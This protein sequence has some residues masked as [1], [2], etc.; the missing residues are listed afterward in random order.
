MSD[1]VNLKSFMLTSTTPALVELA[2]DVEL[3]LLDVELP[4]PPPQAAR[5]M[6]RTTSPTA[7]S[8]RRRVSCGNVFTSRGVTPRPRSHS[9]WIANDPGRK[10]QMSPSKRTNVLSKI[11]QDGLADGPPGFSKAKSRA[12]PY[13]PPK[14]DARPQCRTLRTPG[15]PPPTPTARVRRS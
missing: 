12:T 15:P 6:A 2:V 3:E 13:W 8:V 10:S 7:N 1:G 14:P 11:A 9:L 4:P 5:S